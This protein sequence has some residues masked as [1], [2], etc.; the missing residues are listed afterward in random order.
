MRTSRRRAAALVIPAVVLAAL[1][2]CAPANLPA[3]P[4]TPAPGPH[5]IPTLNKTAA[6]GPPTVRIPSP[7]TGFVN[8][9]LVESVL[10]SDLNFVTDWPTWSLKKPAFRQDGAL[11]CLY[12]AKN[13]DENVSYEVLV[14]PDITAARWA[15][16]L[17]TLQSG[18]E[19]NLFGPSSCATCNSNSQTLN[20]GLNVLTGSTWLSIYAATDPVAAPLN[21]TQTLAQF[22]TVF[23]MAVAATNNTTVIEPAWSDPHATAVNIPSNLQTFTNL[24]SAGLAEPFMLSNYQPDDLM[25]GPESEAELPVG[26]QEFQGEVNQYE[27]DISVLPE[28]LWDYQKLESEASSLPHYAPFSGLGQDAFSYNEPTPGV[29]YQEVVIANKGANL[30]SIEVDVVSPTPGLTALALAKKVAKVFAGFIG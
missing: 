17:P 5:P 26:F 13:G 27:I 11:R 23:A 18:S 14:M 25:D 6:A 21:Q 9:D 28:G 2:G 3:G 7:C 8:L 1:T 29:P 19:P 15:H 24:M 4:L 10:G 22:H 16:Y 20:C 30:I 12:V